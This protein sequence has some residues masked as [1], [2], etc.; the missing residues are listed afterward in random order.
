MFTR[1]EVVEFILDL[2]G[3]T[4]SLPLHRYRLLEPSFGGGDFLLPVVSRLLNAWRAHGQGN[5]AAE[6]SH[7]VRAVELHR[8]SF[9]TTSE[10]L[11]K[12]LASDGIEKSQA[13]QL[14]D[15]WLVNG[16]FLLA[17]LDGTFDLV[18]GNP[19][20][21]RQ[22]LIADALLAEYR[23]RY[24]T[25]YDR[26]DIYV[27]FIE[28]SLLSLNQGGKLGFICADRWMKNRY[29]GPLRQLVAEG[30]RLKV[31][32]NMVDTRLSIRR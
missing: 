26:A 24:R 20:Y 5:A 31:Y 30:F 14:I 17:P 28:R 11:L 19:P 18:V 10:A 12:L 16:D 15:A 7:S 3:Y 25:L 13:G 6:L 2:V 8:A 27:P 4:T 22:E 9:K 23:R 29:G 32:V 1:R 21:V